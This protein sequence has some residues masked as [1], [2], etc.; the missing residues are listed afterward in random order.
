MK[1]ILFLTITLIT[2]AAAQ[3]ITWQNVTANY[4]LPAG[5]AVY[6]GSR[7]SPILSI[8]YLDVDLNNTKLAVRP[9]LSGANIPVNTFTKNVGAYA[10]INGGYFGGTSAYSA[11]IYPNEVKAT[12]VASVTRSTLSYPVIRSFFGMKKD[13]SLSV[14]W[15]YQFGSTM[16]DVYSFA[17]P[18]SYTVNDPTP[19]AAPIKTQGTEMTNLLV[20]IGGGPMLI[21][22][23]T[24]KITYNQ[25][26][27]WGSG[28]G[29]TNN[30]PRTA[31]G[32]TANK[33]V[34]MIVAD[35]RQAGSE[36][37]SLTEMASILKGLGCVGAI[38]LDGGGSTQ[39]ATSDAYI[40]SPSEQR[41]VPAIFAVVH[42][43]SLNL[44]KLPLFE[45]IIDT[46][47][48][49]ATAVGA[50]WFESANPGY[51][52]TKSLLH[53]IGNGSTYYEF[54][55]H[56]PSKAKYNVYGWWVPSSNRSTDTPFII[57]RNG[58]TDTVRVD[59]TVNGSTWKLIGSYEFSGTSSDKVIISD[60]AK[61]NNYV[62]ADAL[63]FESFDPNVVT[64]VPDL[65]SIPV[66]F[67]I[68]QN[69]PNP[70]NPSTTIEY[71][72]KNGSNVKIAVYNSLGAEIETIVDHHHSPG[73]Y[74]VRFNGSALASGMYFYRIQSEGKSITK[75]MMLVK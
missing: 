6:H 22:N 5:I 44:P 18:L 45:K 69:Y 26:V 17:Q 19:K 28:V 24:I 11:V 12:N 72:V 63:K 35:G 50:G 9:Y 33:H 51:W 46:G 54:R 53:P 4:S 61:T 38:N 56:L 23:D 43:D 42:T 70:F 32:Y 39:M 64:S 55:P 49:S 10:A 13:R 52:V 60:A 34:I 62:V 66:S 40:N 41:A 65:S 29:E 21:K 74:M 14:D 20:G 2:A 7:P 16:A 75:G 25:E 67:D 30:D 27:M 31:I 36:G 71:T 68:S 73:A 57:Y 3:T 1:K 47:D 8:Y 37:V 48:S 15:I 59:Q 58:G